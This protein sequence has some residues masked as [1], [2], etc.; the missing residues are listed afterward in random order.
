MPLQFGG[1]NTWFES[2]PEP[3][4]VVSVVGE[5]L[6]FVELNR[7][8]PLHYIFKKISTGKSALVKTRCGIFV[9]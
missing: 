3:G 6:N 9:G 4:R 1:Y 7:T 8:Q 2:L 5:S